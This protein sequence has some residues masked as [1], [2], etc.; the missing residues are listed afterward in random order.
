[1]VATRTYLDQFVGK[2]FDEGLDIIKGLDADDALDNEV[3]AITGATR[4]SGQFEIILNN[5]FTTHQIVWNEN[6]GNRG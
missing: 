6:A 2:T 1:M 3:P 5:A 4:T